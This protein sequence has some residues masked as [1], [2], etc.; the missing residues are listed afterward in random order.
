MT[1]L[2]YTCNIRVDKWRVNRKKDLTWMQKD[3][4]R[5]AG[6]LLFVIPGKCNVIRLV[7]YR[8]NPVIHPSPV[9][10][11]PDQVIQKYLMA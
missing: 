11:W 10:P 2:L 7:F 6:F 3:Y 8:V 5:K 9:I 1:H 4:H